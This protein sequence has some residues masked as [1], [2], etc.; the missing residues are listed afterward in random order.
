MK[1]K[2]IFN[3]KNNSQRLFRGNKFRNMNNNKPLISIIMPNFKSSFFE[4]AIQS[5]VS[6][7]YK[8]IE[9]IIIDGDSGNEALKIIKRY[10]NY[11]NYWVSEKDRGLWDAWNK[12]IELSR[13]D[14][15]G[16]VDST[17]LLNKDAIDILV[18]YIKIVPEADF[19]LGP[20][21]KGK[22][23]YSGFR[24]ENINLKFNIYPSAVVGFYIKKSSLKKVG[25]FNI[26][27]K[28]GADYDFF[29][30]MIVHNKMKG[31]A[32]SSKKIFGSFGTPGISSSFNFFTRLFAELKIR[33]DNQQNIFIIIYILVGRCVSKLFSYILRNNKEYI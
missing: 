13:G 7:K 26:K 3:N 16:I 4:K 11:I 20:V 1:I 10:E 14:Y 23:I 28:I 8:N 9:F 12:G 21:R 33:F 15:I 32:I 27:Y 17:N 24:P 31:L 5:V 29:Y 30:R 22:K 6:Q 2:K 19:F 18:K 25:L